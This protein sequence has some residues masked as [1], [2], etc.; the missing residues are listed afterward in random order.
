MCGASLGLDHGVS[1]LAARE[2]GILARQ[3]GIDNIRRQDFRIFGSKFILPIGAKGNRIEA[4]LCRL[5]AQLVRD[6]RLR[7][8]AAPYS[9]YFERAFGAPYLPTPADLSASSGR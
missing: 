9:A 6:G 4:R 2:I 1:G 8:V 7:E 3:A 5:T